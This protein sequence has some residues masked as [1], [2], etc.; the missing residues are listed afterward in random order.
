MSIKATQQCE[1]Y[2]FQCSIWFALY[3]LILW[4]AWTIYKSTADVRVRA[5][6]DLMKKIIRGSTLMSDGIMGTLGGFDG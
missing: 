3:G 1:Q 2:P 6:G 5:R 4:Y